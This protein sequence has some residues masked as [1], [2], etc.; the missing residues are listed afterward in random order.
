MKKSSFKYIY[1]LTA[2]FAIT[3]MLSGCSN[4]T[5]SDVKFESVDTLESAAADNTDPD[6]I[7][8]G[9]ADEITADEPNKDAA[10]N[11]DG[12]SA[13]NG[14]AENETESKVLPESGV[15]GDY[16]YALE[17]SMDSGYFLDRGYFLMSGDE[18]DEVILAICSGKR[19]TGGYSIEISDID[20][21]DPLM[22]I[23]VKENTPASDMTVTEAFTCPICFIRLSSLPGDLI[24]VTASGDELKFQGNY[25][26]KYESGNDYIAIFADGVGEIMQK[27]YVYKT[28]DGKY[29]YVNVRSVTESYGSPRWID[30]LTGSG[31]VDTKE[32]LIEI[33]RNHNSCGYVQLPFEINDTDDKDYTIITYE[34]LQSHFISIDEFLAQDF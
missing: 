2:L 32:E 20:Y 3:G 22:T 5:S 11:A 29:R 19:S 8:A 34:E 9:T 25:G 27:T 28:D 31:V 33:A 14:S 26:E 1:V 21:T 12:I 15:V 24:I 10:D 17:G 18:T 30:T 13:E 16:E 7:A 4:K 23:T 6:K